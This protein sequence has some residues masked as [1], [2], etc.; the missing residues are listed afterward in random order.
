MLPF[1][2]SYVS[3]GPF[4]LLRLCVSGLCHI[5][6]CSQLRDTEMFNSPDG[7]HGPG[8]FR[9][10]AQGISISWRHPPLRSSSWSLTGTCQLRP[11]IPGP[12]QPFRHGPAFP[13][14]GQPFPARASHSQP[15]SGPGA[16]RTRVAVSPCGVPSPPGGWR[17]LPGAAMAWP[18]QLVQPSQAGRRFPSSR[19]ERLV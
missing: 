2:L 7:L 8:P 6:S 1:P 17:R 15:G 14:L 19:P 16:R 3:L 11:A 4:G 10:P 13:R 9:P 18:R 12:G 5:C